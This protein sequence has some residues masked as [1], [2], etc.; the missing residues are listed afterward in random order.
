MRLTSALVTPVQDDSPHAPGA[1]GI[2]S[3]TYR[4]SHKSGRSDTGLFCHFGISPE[5]W[6][7]LV[8]KV[9]KCSERARVLSGVQKVTG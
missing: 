7:T 6:L 5:F 1:M 2:K 8:V 3:C 9:L 4:E